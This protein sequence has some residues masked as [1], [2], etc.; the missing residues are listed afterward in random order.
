MVSNSGIPLHA[1][2]IRLIV[3]RPMKGE[4]IDVTLMKSDATGIRCAL[5]LSASSQDDGSSKPALDVFDDIWIPKDNL[6]ADCE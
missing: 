4:V 2:I 5:A 6:F 3:F 1:A